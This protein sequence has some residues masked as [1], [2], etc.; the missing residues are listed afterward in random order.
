MIIYPEFLGCYVEE[1]YFVNSLH[2]GTIIQNLKILNL[3]GIKMWWEQNC[4]TWCTTWSVTVQTHGNMESVCFHDEKK[5]FV[6]GDVFCASVLQ[7]IMRKNCS[8]RRHN[9]AYVYHIKTKYENIEIRLSV[10][11][12]CDVWELFLFFSLTACQDHMDLQRV[13]N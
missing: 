2:Y 5:G 3:D 11:I 9:S 4:D 8:K 13:W 6:D 1:G 12:W 10:Y 7:Q